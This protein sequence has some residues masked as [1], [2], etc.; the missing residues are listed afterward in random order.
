[1]A[2]LYKRDLTGQQFGKLTA[3]EDSGKRQHGGVVWNCLCECGNV[4]QVVR[5][6]L[7]NGLTR[8][9]GCLGRGPTA[10]ESTVQNYVDLKSLEPL[11][12]SE[13]IFFWVIVQACRDIVYHTDEEAFL[14]AYEWI[15]DDMPQQIGDEEYTFREALEAIGVDPMNVEHIR[16]TIARGPGLRHEERKR[17]ARECYAKLEG[18]AYEPEPWWRCVQNLILNKEP[19]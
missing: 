12:E 17:L 13:D 3:L 8:S 19:I 2:G 6:S 7:I 4:H 14:H 15:V 10:K 9:C 5:G 16:H 11:C 18:E 1:M